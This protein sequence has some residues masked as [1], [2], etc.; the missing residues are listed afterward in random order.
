MANM[1]VD[2]KVD[3]KVA[4]AKD[5]SVAEKFKQQKKEAAERFKAR[6]A[7]EAEENLANAKALIDHLKKNGSYDKLTPE[8]KSY[9]DGLVA[10]KKS[11]SANGGLFNTLFGA[12]PKVG[13]KITLKDI[14]DKTLK[15]KAAIDFYVKKRWADKGIV[16]EFVQKQPQIMS[17]YVIKELKK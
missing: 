3:G 13:D 14:F 7:K 4:A 1:T 11:V 12:T 16:V 17:E 2:T 15:G 10:P 6:K 8:L 9:V 5:A